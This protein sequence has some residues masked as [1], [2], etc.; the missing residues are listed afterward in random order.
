MKCCLSTDVG[1]W[2]NRLTFEPDLDYHAIQELVTYGGSSGRGPGFRSRTSPQ[3]VVYS[4]TLSLV[5]KCNRTFSICCISPVFHVGL[6]VSSLPRLKRSS[7]K[8]RAVIYKWI[9]S[10]K[11]RNF[12]ALDEGV[13]SLSALWVFSVI[14]YLKL[15]FVTMFEDH[16][17]WV[18]SLF[19]LVRL[20][21]GIATNTHRP[22]G[23]HLYWLPQA[24]TCS[25][26]FIIIIIILRR[27]A[28]CRRLGLQTSNRESFT[29]MSHLNVSKRIRLHNSFLLKYNN[30]KY[31]R[32]CKIP[33]IITPWGL[34]VTQQ[35]RWAKG[36][37]QTVKWS[38]VCVWLQVSPWNLQILQEWH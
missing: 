27:K 14:I 34:W 32:T 18:I 6:V 12:S 29:K 7:S 38:T 4:V 21:S 24:F 20:L 5:C 3:Y 35:Y 37:I 10:S 28:W 9:S 17:G 8:Y 11:S 13:Q 15:S 30:N 1:T 36:Q 22:Q 16:I 2:T 26:V 33:T 31:L 23:V 25:Q 19:G